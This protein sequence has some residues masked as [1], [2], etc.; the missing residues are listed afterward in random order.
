MKNIFFFLFLLCT[1]FVF[2]QEIDLDQFKAMKIR[3]I[4]PAGMSGRVT[5]ID[6]DLSKPN[7]IV[8]G[9]ASGGVWISESGGINWKPVFDKEAVQSIGAVKINQR[10][11]SEI[12]AGTGEGNPRNSSN[13]GG[14]IYKSLD[15][16]YTWKLMGLEKTKS[17]HRI[18]I[19]QE[20]SKV[21]YAGATGSIWGPNKERGVF[22]TTDGG[23]T[24][25]KVLYVNENVGCA[26]L[27]ID[28]NNSNKL[29]AAMWEYG[30]KPWT[31]NSGGPGS[32][33]YITYD[34]GE[35]WKKLTSKEGLPKGDLGRIGLSFAPSNPNVVYALIEAK[36]NGLYKSTDGGKK[37]KLVSTKNIGN[38]PFYYADIFVD[39]LNENKIYNLH[40]VVTTSIDGGKTFTTLMD[41]ARVHPDFH[42]F[43]IHPENPN[44]LIVGNDGGMNISRDNGAN[45]QFIN[46]LP[47]GQFYHIRVDDDFP[48]NIY[49]GMQDNGS[50]VGPSSVFKR[51]GIRNNDWQEVY[52][53]DGFDV[54]PKPSDNRYGYAMSQ[55][56]NLGMYD[57]ET[58][59]NQNIKPVHPEGL[60]LRYNWNA[61]LA[62]NPFQDC[63]IY[64]GSQFVHKSLDCGKSWEIISPDLTTNDSTK[65]RQFESG[66]LT[67]DDTEAENHTTILAIAPST[68]DESEIWVG[69]D[70]GNLQLTRDGGQN[71]TNLSS[72]LPGVP[73]NAW[74]PYI[75]LS[76]VNKGEAFIIV[77][78]YRQNDYQPYAY[79]TKDYGASFTRI[80]GPSNVKGHCLSIVQDPK[81]E[82]LLFMGTDYGLYFSLNK[83]QQWQKWK[84]FPSVSTADLQIQ[85]TTND[86][87]IGT[88]GRAIWIMDDIQPLRELAKARNVLN[89][90]FALLSAND[91][92]QLSYRSYD[93][94]RFYSDGEY[95]GENDSYGA[96]LTYWK[97]PKDKKKKEVPPMIKDKKKKKKKGEEGKVEAEKD[98]V[99]KEKKK[100]SK[101]LKVHVLNMSGDTIRTFSRDV[102]E[103]MNKLTWRM[104]RDGVRY[105]S[106]SEPK[107]DADPPS[108][109]SVMP[110]KYKL[111][112]L[113]KEHKDSL[114]LEV[115][116]DPRIQQTT[117]Q[118]EAK[119]LAIKDFEAMVSKATQSFDQLME[120][121][122]TIKRV[123]QMMIH[124]IDS[125]KENIAKEGKDVAKA[126]AELS[127]LYMD[128]E[129]KKGIQRDKKT[130]VRA[131]RQASGLLRG[132][133]GAPAQNAQYAVA[134]A[135]GK[136]KTILEKVNT[137]FKEDWSTYQKNVEAAR[138]SLFKEVELIELE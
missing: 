35:N 18:H 10:N 22:K 127:D 123:D 37:W 17:I 23:K 86:L 48:Y 70:D 15:G 73:R 5:S 19:H 28:P 111:V 117:A 52:F 20:D 44:F 125:T 122:R 55:G 64:Y 13:M 136:L 14:G 77:N 85:E 33:L 132:S 96:Y 66:G 105:P 72:R 124:A 138:S 133:Q 101:K 60:F 49:G 43:W 50:W 39:P 71:W 97:K 41:W 100:N 8:I 128:A 29:I 102:Q 134:N 24:W 82:N 57:K 59:R 56:G 42:A 30:R 104:N 78:N 53:G 63:G 69:T 58:G 67:I 90:D 75:E 94:I 11:T 115:F 110:G 25:K 118:R 92:Y 65:Q 7:K 27:I 81:E 79:H 131:L 80:A 116:S 103:G 135:K 31:F 87:V 95:T 36:E 40:S 91:G 119:A 106:R 32:G 114:E 121:K 68:H 74:F 9:A 4:G 62:Q 3:N 99:E 129:N 2:A 1:S 88:F 130:L 46:N 84:S 93:G 113:Y 107:K 120:A 83:G 109:P 34:G 6:V 89:K 54:M 47:L 38:R 98:E 108:G 112:V 51:G 137:F 12:W 21:V 45:W 76:K 61:A 16:G 126:I 26:D